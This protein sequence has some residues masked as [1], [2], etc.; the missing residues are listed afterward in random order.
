MSKAT[1]PAISL[2][3][4]RL[5]Q[6]SSAA[7]LILGAL[8]P[9]TLPAQEAAT[10]PAAAAPQAPPPQQIKVADLT[11]KVLSLRV[12]APGHIPGESLGSLA[13]I[14]FQ[15]INDSNRPKAVNFVKG[16]TLFVND[17]GYPW[18]SDHYAARFSGLPVATG[19]EAS[20]DPNLEP[21][22]SINATMILA[23]GLEQGQTIGGVYDLQFSV[24]TYKDLGEGRVIKERTYPVQFVNM[25]RAIA[26]AALQD[27]G[28]GLKKAFV[29]LFGN[30]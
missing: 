3:R 16:S 27:A 5:F 8:A 9:L 19:S 24:A 13:T 6:I 18:K 1:K 30:K 26:G 22:G 12:S 15:I 14:S 11:F 4:R 7:V 21:G 20:S 28:Q 23:L 25:Q 29:E 17:L 2:S 10:S